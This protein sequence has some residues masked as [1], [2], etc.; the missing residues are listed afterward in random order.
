[1]PTV[2]VLAHALY[3]RVGRYLAFTFSTRVP[4]RFVVS[5]SKVRKM[6]TNFLNPVTASSLITIFWVIHYRYIE[7]HA[8]MGLFTNKCGF[9]IQYFSALQ[10]QVVANTEAVTWSNILLL[11]PLFLKA[12]CHKSQVH[13]LLLQFHFRP[14]LLE[15]IVKCSC[16]IVIK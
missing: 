6:K 9:K 10:R 7:K 4:L 12:I 14:T 8:K 16:R 5:F 1:V 2:L 3:R 13:L 11:F 15:S